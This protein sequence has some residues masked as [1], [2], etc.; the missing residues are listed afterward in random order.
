M[1]LK[2]NVQITASQSDISTKKI[3]F[4]NN[5]D[6]GVCVNKLSLSKLPNYKNPS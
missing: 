6:S 5:S 1:S 3:L 2:V 4:E